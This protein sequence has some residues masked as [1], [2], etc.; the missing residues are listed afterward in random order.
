MSSPCGKC[1]ICPCGTN[2]SS[3]TNGTAPPP[4]PPPEPQQQQQ[5][6]PACSNPD[7]CD[8]RVGPSTNRSQAPQPQV[9]SGGGC[10]VNVYQPP[11]PTQPYQPT[12]RPNV[13]CACTQNRQRN[14]VTAIQAPLADN[15]T[16]SRP[17]R[18][19]AP[20]PTETR[21]NC[22]EKPNKLECQCA[23][24]IAP[25]V[26]P[27]NRYESQPTHANVTCGQATN[28]QGPPPYVRRTNAS[29]CGHCRSQRKRKKCSIQ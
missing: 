5:Q 28:P 9:P 29:Q 4:P 14:R 15:Y 3:G 11:P 22:H 23:P 13:D 16:C 10:Q 24:P 1:N 25:T 8:L 2:G 19:E 12:Q 18:V 20:T 26:A 27:P 6:P 17:Q 21:C 7:H